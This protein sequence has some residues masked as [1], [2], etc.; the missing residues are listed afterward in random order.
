MTNKPAV[1]ED[2]R[3]AVIAMGF[4][5]VPEILIID[6]EQKV[7]DVLSDALARE[8]C[9]LTTCG[10]AAEGLELV[11]QQKFDLILLDLGLPDID[12][13]AVLKV[14]KSKDESKHVP[15]IVLTGWND[16]TDKVT[17]FDLGAVDYITKPFEVA[18]LRARVRSVLRT[19]MLQEQLA[20]ANRAL[21][22]ARVTAESG[23]R[24]KSEFLAN[25]SHE[26]RTPMNGVI[27]VAS[28]LGR[29][30]LNE[31]Q[32][33]L[34]ETIR[35]SGEVLLNILNDILD[36]SK[37]E[38]G[39]FELD[40]HPFQLRKCVEET[41]DLIAAKATEKHLDLI[42]DM[43]ATV[44]EMIVGDNNRLRQILLNLLSNAIKFTDQGE[45]FLEIKLVPDICQNLPA[46]NSSASAPASPSDFSAVRLQFSVH[47]TGIGIPVNKLD[48]LF[49]SFSQVDATTTRQFGG[50]G[51]GLSISKK[52][53]ELMD[54]RIWVESKTD[55]GS[56]FHFTLTAQPGPA[57]SRDLS[58]LKGRHLL[59][60]DDNPT[61]RRTLRANAQKWEMVVTTVENGTEAIE[62]LT[63]REA[64]DAILLEMKPGTGG[65]LVQANQIRKSHGATACVLIA[66]NSLGERLHPGQVSAT[67]FQ[68]ALTKPIKPEL[69]YDALVNGIYGED[70]PSKK[71]SV[72]NEADGNLA[73]E[74]PLSLLV[75]DDDPVNQMVALRLLKQMGYRADVAWT[76]KE[77]IATSE[78]RHYDIIF[79]DLQMPQLDGLDATRRIRQ[80]EAESSHEASRSIIIAMTANAMSGDREKCLAA[81]M[82]DYISKP[83]RPD[84]L[85]SAVKSWGQK[86]KKQPV[87]V[88]RTTSAPIREQGASS[89]IVT[90]GSSENQ[91]PGPP[92]NVGRLMDFAAGDQAA[93]DQLVEIYLSQTTGRM[94]KIGT[95]IASGAAKD[96]EQ[97]AHACAGAS[98]TCGM[99][100]IASLFQE[101]LRQGKEKNL[102]AAPLQ[103]AKLEKEFER[104]RQ[105]LK[106]LPRLQS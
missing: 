22:A 70:S 32:W 62:T 73:T 26:I 11:R 51:L 88:V 61:Q 82:D 98:S 15:V 80:R 24:A 48:R 20:L 104:I 63:S 94:A 21:E 52:L 8:N 2:D 91:D 10:S 45:V 54:G 101:L 34:V 38:S 72:V 59:I 40:H 9:R 90:P 87:E 75:V 95:A 25:M 77:A 5:A 84:V 56:T 66:M 27:A 12:G 85:R 50:T 81:G 102:S 105:F 103:F 65:N 60:I 78:N 74:L 37:I 86:L 99:A 79:M 14:L 39:K 46:L 83:V 47:D 18:E 16:I 92:V 1:L 55:Q 69:L 13:F 64:F 3:G 71:A 100:P 23:T 31:E 93:L 6:D 89:S 35:T 44:P 67:G 30:Q 49:K 97:L 106:A 57:V 4:A 41:L 58:K 28:L 19:Q 68:S 96:V 7:L 17:G 33:S 76:G 36:Y 43:G 42:Y 29:T 53:V